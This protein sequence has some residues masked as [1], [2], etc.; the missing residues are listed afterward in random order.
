MHGQVCPWR[1][2]PP[3]PDAPGGGPRCTSRS[4]L[5]PCPNKRPGVGRC[6]GERGEYTMALLRVPVAPFSRACPPGEGRTVTRGVRHDTVGSAATC[7]CYICC[8]VRGYDAR[9]WRICDA[10]AALLFAADAVVVDAAAAAAASRSDGRPTDEGVLPECGGELDHFVSAKCAAWMY[11]LR[12]SSTFGNGARWVCAL[13]LAGRAGC[14]AGSG[15]QT[16]P[17]L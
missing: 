15:I 3:S 16:L 10:A 11:R 8:C 7:C 17:P 13:S 12:R 5:P 2:L 6:G 4:I 9:I 1:E 14:G